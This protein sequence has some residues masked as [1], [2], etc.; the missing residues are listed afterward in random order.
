MMD[1]SI[2]MKLSIIIGV[3]HMIFGVVLSLVN[4]CYFKRCYSILLQFIPEVVFYHFILL[5]C[6]YDFL[7]MVSF[8]LRNQLIKS[9]AHLVPLKY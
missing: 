9:T 8:I 4:F 1:N 6:N 5:A 2:K 7:Q 3:V